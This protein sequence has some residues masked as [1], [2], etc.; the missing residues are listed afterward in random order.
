MAAMAA[1][2]ITLV[3][4]A[5]GASLATPPYLLSTLFKHEA[6]IDVV[7]IPYKG[8]LRRQG[9]AP[10]TKGRSRHLSCPGRVQRAPSARSRASSTR[11]A[12]AERDTD[13]RFT[14]D[15]HS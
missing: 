9:R 7:Y 5:D 3:V 6:G 14:R 1:T 12:R 4:V 2:I 11:Y 8:T 10:L 15:R 13:L